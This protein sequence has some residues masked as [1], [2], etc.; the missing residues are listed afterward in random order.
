MPPP[1]LELPEFE[2]SGG[3]NA[4]H[5]DLGGGGG[6]GG[7]GEH[8]YIYIYIYGSVSPCHTSLEPHSQGPSY[9]VQGHFGY[10]RGGAHSSNLS[11]L[12]RSSEG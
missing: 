8:I 10:I 4:S 7:G 12:S 3:E 1:K 5:M 2:K 11:V 9:W 6:G